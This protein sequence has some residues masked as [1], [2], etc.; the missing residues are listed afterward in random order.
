MKKIVLATLLVFFSAQS[1]ACDAALQK[2]SR[3]CAIQD[4]LVRLKA[5]LAAKHVNIDEVAEYRVIRF[6][7]RWSW[8]NAKHN[9][10]IPLNIYQPAPLTWEV[11]DHGI[12]TIFSGQMNG[13]LAGR[14]QLSP[15]T[16][17]MINRVLLTNGNDSI[18]D[19]N[20][21]QSKKPGDL[22]RATDLS[23]GFC[24]PKVADTTPLIDRSKQSVQRFQASWEHSVGMTF[25]QLVRSKNGI[26]PEKATL[27]ANIF[28]D[29]R[30][31][32][33]AGNS[34]VSYAPGEDVDDNLNWIKIFVDYNVSLYRNNRAVL[35]P[36]A[37]AAVAQKWFV[38]T[39]PFA[40]GNGRTSRGL[41][42]LI[43]ANFGLPYA[44]AGDLQNDA[45]EDNEV[46]I[47]NTYTRMESM[48]TQL[49]WC[50][51]N[52]NYAGPL[53]NQA[54]QCSTVQALNRQ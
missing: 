42:D 21:D 10:T 33:G 47:N 5:N 36:I 11:W 34:W 27:V 14:L 46:Y 13:V 20:T 35:A 44:P 19:P 48:L 22:R 41:E 37:L 1:R 12:R 30:Y 49:E 43:L 31:Q 45:L 26:A 51:A 28:Q 29:N 17:S 39:H 23:V 2:F 4:R 32:C 53:Q 7:D 50:A 40:D 16:F 8:E 15:E 6:V 24:N 25:E 18:K 3:D 9:R 52:T 54:F 38:T